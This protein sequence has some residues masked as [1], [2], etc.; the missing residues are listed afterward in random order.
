MRPLLAL[1]LVAAPLAAQR[2]AADTAAKGGL[3]S[4]TLAGLRFRG[5]GPAMTSGRISDIAIHPSDRSTWYVG[6]ASG[7]LR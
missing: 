5:I 4:A 1:L 6:V 7:G 3:T 2:P